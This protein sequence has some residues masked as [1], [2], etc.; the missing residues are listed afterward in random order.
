MKELWTLDEYVTEQGES[1]IRTFLSGLEASDLVE[2]F[3]LIHLARERGNTLRLP[4]SKALG[5]W[6]ARV[7]RKTGTNLLCC[8]TLGDGLSF[9]TAW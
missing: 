9:S 4:H 8:S 7:T 2:A 5:E 6:I 3:G 1:L